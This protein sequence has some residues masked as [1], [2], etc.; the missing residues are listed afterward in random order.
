MPKVSIKGKNMPSL[1]VRKLV[2]YTA[3]I[4]VVAHSEGGTPSWREFVT[5]V[6]SKS[7][8]IDFHYPR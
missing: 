6:H 3:A 1:P 8:K 5:C 2:P 7:T 4:A